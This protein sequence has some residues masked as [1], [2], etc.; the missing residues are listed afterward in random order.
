ML[1]YSTKNFG[2]LFINIWN[3]HGI[4]VGFPE[5]VTTCME[6]GPGFLNL[7]YRVAHSCQRLMIMKNIIF[8]SYSLISISSQDIFEIT[9]E[10]AVITFHIMFHRLK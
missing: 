9:N 6:I 8:L 5:I 3:V 1:Y 7:K 4:I 10:G 2:K